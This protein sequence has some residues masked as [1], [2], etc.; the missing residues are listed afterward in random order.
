[1]GM[2]D[3]VRVEVPIDGVPCPSAMEWQTKD[4]DMPAMDLY[5][6]S[7]DGR[8]QRQLVRYED[9]SDPNAPPDS[10]VSFRGSMTA[11]PVGWADTNHHGD[12]RMIGCALHE[13]DWRDAVWVV[14]RFT[15]GQLASI[16]R[17]T[18]GEVGI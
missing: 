2:F 12:V 17:E 18:Q 1:M 3:Y 4:L 7:A 15:N 11:V 10:L 13:P 14:A 5:R 16:Q 8:L 6:I 9:R